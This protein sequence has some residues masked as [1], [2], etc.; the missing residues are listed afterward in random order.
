MFKKNDY[1]LTSNTEDNVL[2]IGSNSMGV[3]N[4]KGVSFSIKRKER[5]VILGPGNSG[6]TPII[7]TILGHYKNLSGDF[8]VDGI[9]SEEILF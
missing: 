9:K 4:V 3:I 7:E 6:A 5:F 1:G 8:V 2:N